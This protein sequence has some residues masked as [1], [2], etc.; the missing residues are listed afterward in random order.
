MNFAIDRL[1]MDRE[2]I[3]FILNQAVGLLWKVYVLGKAIF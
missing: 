2:R 1:Q 3:Q